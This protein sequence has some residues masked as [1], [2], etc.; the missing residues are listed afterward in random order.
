MTE[1]AKV[2]LLE[3]RATREPI[4]DYMASFAYQGQPGID[5]LADLSWLDPQYGLN[6]CAWWVI[7]DQSPPFALYQKYGDE[8]LTVDTAR[9]MVVC[10]KQVIPWTAEEIAAYKEPI[11]ATLWAQIKLQRDGEALDGKR[12]D[13][14]VL[15]SGHW[16][17][18]D[19]ASRV[20]WLGLKDSA[21]D[22]LAAGGQLTDAIMIDGAQV[23]WKTMSG[24]YIASE[25]VPVDGQLAFDVVEAF[26]V[27]DKQ[28]FEAAEQHRADLLA[29]YDPAVYDYSTGW[30]QR[31]L[32][33]DAQAEPT[34]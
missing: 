28:L 19:I 7:D 26:K 3:N 13:G 31:F 27:L 2:Y 25:L 30:P 23:Q 20:K 5:A 17:D 24:Q 32:D 18:S 34:P 11:Q 29:A 1:F 6:D 9:K 21:R 33:A 8:T 10:V 15:V 12:Y 14:G 22:L 16:F 4:P